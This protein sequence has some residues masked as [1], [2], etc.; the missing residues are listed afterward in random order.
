[1]A[2]LDLPCVAAKSSRPVHDT[3]TSGAASHTEVRQ[4]PPTSRPRNLQRPS[5]VQSRSRPAARRHK[6]LCEP[7]LALAFLVPVRIVELTWL[8]GQTGSLPTSS[9][10]V[11]EQVHYATVAGFSI[12]RHSHWAVLPETMHVD[13]RRHNPA[14]LASNTLPSGRPTVPRHR[15]P[16]DSVVLFFFLFFFSADQQ[17]HA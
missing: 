9:H 7:Q 6:Q 5:L 13:A 8:S 10:T 14:T 1:M 17:R 11:F 16:S 3:I 4:T 15:L 2:S 12:A